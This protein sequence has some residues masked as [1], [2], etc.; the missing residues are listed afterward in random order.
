MKNSR[1]RRH[2]ALALALVALLCTTAAGFP[3]FANDE[4]VQEEAVILMES[5]EPEESPQE[6]PLPQEES[7]DEAAEGPEAE[8]PEEALTEAIPPDEE[9]PPTEELPPAEDPEVI[10]PV[11]E[12]PD[13]QEDPPPEDE[14]LY[15]RFH[16]WSMDDEISMTGTVDLLD[17][18]GNLLR[19]LTWEDNT[20]T[21]PHV[22]KLVFH[23]PKERPRVA[24]RVLS[25]SDYAL[26]SYNE[27]TDGDAI[28]IPPMSGFLYELWF[29]QWDQSPPPLDDPF[30]PQNNPLRSSGTRLRTAAYDSRGDNVVVG[31]RLVDTGWVLTNVML[32]PGRYGGNYEDPWNEGGAAAF[33][34]S[35]QNSTLRDRD[36]YLWI[37]T[38]WDEYR[39]VWNRDYICS[40]SH[41]YCEWG[42][43]AVPLVGWTG[44]TYL[45]ITKIEDGW[46]YFDYSW[47]N[48]SGGAYWD[49]YQAIGGHGKYPLIPT[50]TP[51]S[52]VKSCSLPELIANNS[53]YS[54]AGAVYGIYSDA[55]CT[56]E[57]ERITTDTNGYASTAGQ[58][59][60][61]TYYVKELSPS[62]GYLLD[63]QV[64]TL[65]I[66]SAGN[67]ST[68]TPFLED[69]STAL[70]MAAIFKSSNGASFPITSS[71][72]VLKV[73]FFP[74]DSWSGT[75]SRTWYYKTVDGVC[76]LGDDAYLDSKRLSSDCWLDDSAKAITLPL[77]TVRISEEEAPAGYIKTNTVLEAKV[78]QDAA[79]SC[80]TWHWTS[81]E[82][83]DIHYLTD[84]AYLDNAAVPGQFCLS[85]HAPGGAAVEGCGFLL[86]F[87]TDDGATWSPVFAPPKDGDV[88]PGTCSSPGLADGVLFTDSTG[89]AQFTGLLADNSTCYRLI[90]VR[91][92]GGKQLLSEPI[93]LGPLPL[94]TE[95]EGPT[96]EVDLTNAAVFRLPLTGGNGFALFP[97][98]L[99]SS[100]MGIAA[101]ILQKR[102]S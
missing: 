25:G 50:G 68:D 8:A 63:T 22:A 70:D 24:V 11:E 53:C 72:T 91:T 84:G 14:S 86:Q 74:N 45:T 96:R 58:Y 52:L 80:A 19:T 77:G 94:P 6:L 82:S 61:G 66:D 98:L 10:L 26:F 34:F 88:Y 83:A 31:Q 32:V 102:K 78:S 101:V 15:D 69:P 97:P 9:A 99:A 16:I 89:Q 39:Y 28:S 90:E 40:H 55:A 27:Y 42:G 79:G 85:K 65:T 48:S 60:A 93:D 12:A 51:I 37:T 47:L 35:L 49:S 4:I 76:K 41:G 1:L 100:A 62:A 59:S 33:F 23:A 46:V 75:P 18:D 71:D 54:L 21:V 29:G 95:N 92:Q 2:F 56:M 3:A 30:V 20:V 57:L 5:A 73:E 87:S 17:A 81:A 13:V 7:A 43:K 44:P 67:L 36:V 64:H 38:S